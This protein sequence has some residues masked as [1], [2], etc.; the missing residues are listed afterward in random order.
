ME[1]DDEIKIFRQEMKGVRRIRTTP[2]VETTKTEVPEPSLLHRRQ[3]AVQV[4]KGD[5]N[6]LTEEIIDLVHPLDILDYRT[7][8]VAHGVYRKLKRGQYPIHARLH[9][10]RNSMAEARADLHQKAGLRY[11]ER[12]RDY[13]GG[14]DAEGVR[15]GHRDRNQHLLNVAAMM[16]ADAEQEVPGL[17]RLVAESRPSGEAVAQRYQ[18][19]LTAYLRAAARAHGL[20][21]VEAADIRLD[22]F[23]GNYPE[24]E[25]AIREGMANLERAYLEIA[26]Q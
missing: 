7:D 9:L 4:D 17:A 6:H 11:M 23:N 18:K 13:Q 15:S 21:Y 26:E 3:M 24:G 25:A 19:E 10:H 22:W 20:W 8:G 12:R 14:S 2:R 5:P 16:Q 1:D